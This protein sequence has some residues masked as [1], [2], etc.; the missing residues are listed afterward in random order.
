MTTIK[1]IALTLIIIGAL[2]WGLIGFFQ[3]DL[4]AG[5]FGGQDAGL[6]R[7]IYTLVGISGVYSIIMLYEWMQEKSPDRGTIRKRNFDYRTEFGEDTDIPRTTKEDTD[8]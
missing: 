1:R 7:V 3:Y 4:V 5:I 2:N 8:K 6:S